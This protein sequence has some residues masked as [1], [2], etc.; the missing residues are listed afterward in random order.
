MKAG[1]P[2]GVLNIMHGQHDAVNFLCDSPIVQSV[3]FVGSTAAGEHIYKRC[4]SSVN[5]K[6]AQCNMGAKNYIIIDSSADASLATAG[7]IGSA[8]GAA[9]T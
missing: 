6:R 3:S 2:K 4:A 1:L 9:G 7:L 5:G 8:F